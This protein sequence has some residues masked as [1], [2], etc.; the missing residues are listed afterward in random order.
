MNLHER[1]WAMAE[2][3]KIWEE[4]EYGPRFAMILIS[5]MIIYLVIVE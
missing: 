4:R 5:A 2:L 1:L 3:I